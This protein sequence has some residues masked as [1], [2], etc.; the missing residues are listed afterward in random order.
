MRVV[1]RGVSRSHGILP[2][3]M[4]LQLLPSDGDARRR[5]TG[6]RGLV[7][8]VVAAL[9]VVGLG[10][11]R[12]SAQQVQEQDAI[13]LTGRQN[14]TLGAGARAYGMGGAFLARPDDATAASWNP[15]GLSYLRLPEV[16]LVANA[17]SFVIKQGDVERDRFTGSA[18]DFAAFT[19]PVS[20]GDALGAIQVSYQRAIGF[21]GTREI[22]SL[23]IRIDGQSDGGFDVLAFGTGLRPFRSLRFGVTVNRWFNGY[24]QLLYRQVPN[25]P[26]PLRELTLDFHLGGWSTNLGLIWSPAENVNIGA[27]FKTP[28][29]AAVTLSKRRTDTWSAEPEF[30]QVTYNSY[31]SD[32]VR[33]EL[34]ASYGFGVSWRPRDTLT[35]SADLTRTRWSQAYILNYFSLNA[36]P[37]RDDPAELPAPPPPTIADRLPYPT[38]GGDGALNVPVSQ[39]DA[40]QIRAGIEYV[41]ITGSLKIPLR[42]GYFND[43]QITVYPGQDA[44]RFNGVTVGTGIVLGSLLLDVAYLHEFGNYAVSVQEVPIYGALRANRFFVS[45]IYRLARRP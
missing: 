34:P 14:L 20:V 15:A 10:A 29:T 19:W 5:W 22:V 30:D 39:V 1:T 41:L 37:Q 44:P 27:V 3:P 18:F 12:A 23:P 43:R 26:P 31:E 17:N 8:A 40:E 4:R 33:L 2:A 38:L 7:P 28:F 45:A 13:D 24:E 32:D 9:V 16:S 11:K 21:D 42:A 6:R 35:L 36:T 25:R